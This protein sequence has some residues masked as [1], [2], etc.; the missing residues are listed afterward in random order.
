[1]SITKPKS[2]SK[3]EIV[4]LKDLEN[5]LIPFL[6]AKDRHASIEALLKEEL[7]LSNFYAKVGAKCVL[8]ALE[9]TC[10]K[11][12]SAHL[13]NV[14]D[15]LSDNYEFYEKASLRIGR[16]LGYKL[17]PTLQKKKAL[18][19][20]VTRMDNVSEETWNRFQEETKL[21]IT[22]LAKT[23]QILM[24]LGDLKAGV[25]LDLDSKDENLKN[26]P[27]SR[28]LRP[29]NGFIPLLGR[30]LDLDVLD[31]FSST[32]DPFSWMIL[33]GE[34]GVGKTRLIHE[35]MKMKSADGWDTGFLAIDSLEQFVQHPGFPNWQPIVDT[36]IAIDYAA[37]KSSLLKSFI[38]RCVR[39]ASNS[40]GTDKARLRLLLLERHGSLE[41]K[42]V[43]NLLHTGEGRIRTRITDTLHEIRK[44][45]PPGHTDPDSLMLEILRY[46]FRQWEELTG[47]TPPPLP[48]F[49]EKGLAHF[50]ET[51]QRRPLLIQLAGLHACEIGDANGLTRWTREEL[52]APSLE[53]E[54]RHIQELCP[55]K[56]PL[57]LV[58]RCAAM[59]TILGGV[60]SGNPGWLELIRYEATRCGYP[61]I[62]S[63][64]LEEAAQAAV[65][66]D[67]TST[68]IK[69]S[70]ITPD[71]LGAAFVITILRES[72]QIIGETIKNM[73]NYS[74]QKTLSFMLRAV[75][76]LYFIQGLSEVE[77]WLLEVISN[78]SK[79]EL[80]FAEWMVPEQ[81]TALRNIGARIYEKQLSMFAEH[82]QDNEELA[83]I[84]NSLG[85]WYSAV[86]RLEDALAASER[87]LEIRE[88]LAKQNP[89]AFEPELAITLSNL[90]NQRNELGRL[91]DAVAASERAVKI[92]KR[93][94]KRNPEVFEPLLAAV[95]NN[96]G[97]QCGALGRLEDALAASELASEIRERLAQR[98][99]EAFE[100]FLAMS[101]TNLGTQYSAHGRLED[102]L[103]ATE[104]AAEIYERLAKRNPDSFEPDLATILNNQGNDYRALG[105]LEDAMT[106][107]KRALKIRKR[108]AKRNPDA[109]E[110]DLAQSLSNLGPQYS[111]HGL[112]EDALAS[113]EQAMEIYERLAKQNPEAFEP[114]LA[115]TSN[116]LGSAY[117]ALGRREDALAATEHALEIY[118]RLVKRNPDAFEPVL[119]TI[120]NNLGTAYG[121]LGRREDALA[122]SERAVK[123]YK[124]LA[125]RNPEA[126][127]PDLAT[128]LN[129]LGI[130][131]RALGRQE[132]ALVASELASEIRERLAERNPEA[133]EPDLAASMNILGTLYSA[134]GRREDALVATERALEIYERLAN[135]NP[136]GFEPDLALSLNNL[137]IQYSRLGRREDALAATERAVEIRER[138]AKRNPEAFEPDLAQSLNNIGNRYGELG[139]HEDATIALKRAVEIRERLAKRNPDA[140]EP[141][142]AGSLSNLGAQYSALGHP[143]EAMTVSE[144]AMEIHKRMAKRNPEAFEPDLAQSLGACGA[145]CKGSNQHKKAAGFYHKG[146]MIIKHHF[147]NCPD[148]HIRIVLRLLRD[149]NETCQTAGVAIDDL[150]LKSIMEKVQECIDNRPGK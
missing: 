54:R 68:E 126:F 84:W 108:L 119:A 117:N 1:M 29:Y 34:G 109:F 144:R 96:L 5:T 52:I 91:E 139:Q 101:L 123:I 32:N 150:S 42:W 141:E 105:R 102:A 145:I 133:F 127:E 148:A 130:A 25:V 114:D 125:K 33:F 63:A 53:R 86:G 79:E 13:K 20:Y 7:G 112:Q 118:K 15:A 62:D 124:R 122:A 75:M 120:L 87:A 110:P 14:H 134:F 46:T 38:L 131:Y 18:R 89:E 17:E 6:D 93:L 65:G 106:A 85:A 95:L 67:F 31:K 94:A 116:N 57:K 71:I 27:F 103:A 92:Y 55:E 22:Q 135:Q 128:F 19:E 113:S 76:D 4:N 140:F 115:R 97:P 8:P 59:V 21:W 47:N 10:G 11:I 51:T 9:K 129:N 39:W 36:V 137:G 138:L 149:Y 45:T 2:K 26:L 69:I 88:R 81:T 111:A 77:S 3:N 83:R 142:L 40:A 80:R 49:D 104:R 107:S 37:S 78:C 16:W 61:S 24:M 82:T 28:W 70:A 43:T 64:A 66:L 30:E 143:K 147:L 99:P 100:P 56:L 132:D 136:D 35:F 48:D 58:E 98:N 72:P 60:Y 41:A 12:I 146:L 23:N 73:V 90:G 50:Q 44:I 74:P 121:A